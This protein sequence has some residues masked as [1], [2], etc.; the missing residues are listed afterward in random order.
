MRQRW[1]RWHPNCTIQAKVLKMVIQIDVAA[2]KIHNSRKICHNSCSE[3]VVNLLEAT[4]HWPAHAP[5]REPTPINRMRSFQR[6]SPP[7][8]AREFWMAGLDPAC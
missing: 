7:P 5:K 2:R 6:N 1:R 3:L 8:P 4:C